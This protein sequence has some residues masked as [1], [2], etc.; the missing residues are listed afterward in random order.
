MYYSRS[1][2]T[3]IL[4]LRCVYSKLN[5]F[6]EVLVYS[7]LVQEIEASYIAIA[8]LMLFENLFA[9]FLFIG[10]IC[11]GIFMVEILLLRLDIRSTYRIFVLKKSLISFQSSSDVIIS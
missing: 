5:A 9:S 3:F 4:N 10:C 2:E 1:F 7:P 6:K 8:I 11:S